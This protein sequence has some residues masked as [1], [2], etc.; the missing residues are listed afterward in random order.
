MQI[1]S[2][3][4]GSSLLVFAITTFY[5]DFF[6]KPNVSARIFPNINGTSIELTNNGRV[7]ATN[8]IVTVESPVDIANSKVFTTENFTVENR[9]IM[10]EENRIM[11]IEDKQKLVAKFPRFVHGDGSLIKMEISSTRQQWDALNQNYVIYATYDQ[12]SLRIASQMQPTI[13]AP[14]GPTIA[15]TIAAL[16]TFA[17][18][19]FYRRAKRNRQRR[20]NHGVS[21]VA[22][23]ISYVKQYC[24]RDPSYFKSSQ[25]HDSTAKSIITIGSILNDIK[26]IFKN[27]S[28]FYVVSDFYTKSARQVIADGGIKEEKEED[29]LKEI[30]IKGKIGDTETWIIKRDIHILDPL[31]GLQKNRKDIAENAERTLGE[32]RWEQY[33]I[34]MT[35]I[36]LTVSSTH[37]DPTDPAFFLLNFRRYNIAIDILQPLFAILVIPVVLSIGSYLI[38][39]DPLQW[40]QRFEIYHWVLFASA[41][42]LG[43][44][45]FF[46]RYFSDLIFTLVKVMMVIFT[47]LRLSMPTTTM[48]YEYLRKK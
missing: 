36:M 15:L 16:L 6:N 13:N 44:T 38:S 48:I 45:I 10:I 19:F 2:S 17:I 39:G 46:S 27:E 3:V 26:G 1:V 20:H 42:F 7:P 22:E 47:I 24:E 25:I 5:S 11:M 33:D 34:N 40:I 32:I 43:I 9:T 30:L 35:Y 12:G 31:Q 37:Y 23:N 29:E 21:R 28:D 8:L 41:A 18:P 4:I 14:Y